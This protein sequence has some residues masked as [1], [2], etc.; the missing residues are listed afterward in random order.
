M[1]NGLL[2]VLLEFIVLMDHDNRVLVFDLEMLQ[3]FLWS[4]QHRRDEIDFQ[5][6]QQLLLFNFRHKDIQMI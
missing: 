5:L 1:I 6:E 2:K 3:H 4:P